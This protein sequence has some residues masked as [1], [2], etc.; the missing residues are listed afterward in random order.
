MEARG[1]EIERRLRRETDKGKI[2]PMR[3]DASCHAL[4]IS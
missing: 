2:L 3:D 1:K 4:I